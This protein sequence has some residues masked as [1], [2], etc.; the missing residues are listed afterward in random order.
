[1]TEETKPDFLELG[2][3]LMPTE[4]LE[5]PE[6]GMTVEL[7]GLTPRQIKEANRAAADK[8]SKLKHGHPAP[9]DVDGEMLTAHL[10]AMSIWKDGERVISAGREQELLDFPRP[11]LTFLQDAVLR[12]NGMAKAE[13]GETE[14]NS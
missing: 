3:K 5:I 2:K 8:N 13:E 6:L 10:I 12:I 7:R 4:E 9:D 14:G 11:L 1:L